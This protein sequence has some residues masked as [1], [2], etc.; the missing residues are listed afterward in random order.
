MGGCGSLIFREVKCAVIEG[1]GQSMGEQND[2]KPRTVNKS[3]FPGSPESPGLGTS[4]RAAPPAPAPAVLPMRS[5]LPGFWQ[6]YRRAV[7]FL[8]F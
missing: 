5:L 3:V 1:N 2:L 8:A 4:A 6:I 7:L